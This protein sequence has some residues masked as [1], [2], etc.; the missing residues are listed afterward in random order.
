MAEDSKQAKQSSQG[1]QLARATPIRAITPFDE[2][3][4]MM[5]RMFADFFP[6]SFLQPFGWRGTL[7][8]WEPLIPRVDVIEKDDQIVV[9]AE[10]PGVRKEDL[11]VAIRDT[12]LTIKAD[13][14]SEEEEETGQYFRRERRTG[15][16]S[17]TLTLPA[18]VESSKAK[19]SFRDGILELTLPKAE[20]ARAHRVPIE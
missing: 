4:R 13:T 2:I 7:A 15:S 20:H 10:L 3:E 19:A 11:D 16:F 12:M 8:E 18:E 6:R 1:Q 17:R 9:R 5:D 14:H